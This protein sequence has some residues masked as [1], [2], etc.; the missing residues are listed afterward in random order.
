MILGRRLYGR[1]D[2][3][4]GLGYVAARFFHVNFVPLFPTGETFLVV[5]H[6]L[7]SERQELVQ[8]KN[9]AKPVLLGYARGAAWTAALLT[10]FFAAL[11]VAHVVSTGE[12]HL[13]PE[14]LGFLAACAAL[15]LLYAPR[16]L[17]KASAERAWELAA[18]SGVG[19]VEIADILV[20]APAPAPRP[21][22][23]RLRGTSHDSTTEGLPTLLAAPIPLAKALPT[24]TRNAVKFEC[25]ICE[26]Q[27]KVSA[28]YVGKKGPC[29]ACGLT[30][31]V[32]AP[33]AKRPLA[34]RPRP[35]I[36]WSFHTDEPGSR[37]ERHGLSRG[38]RE[39]R[40]PS[41]VLGWSPAPGRA[42][43]LGNP[44]RAPGRLAPHD[45][46]LGLVG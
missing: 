10:S 1:T 38:R 32:P 35:K 41:A 23:R 28:E 27:S 13:R 12:P 36:E 2:E 18:E 39:P 25:P 42:E 45:A 16:R 17:R 11:N 30:L 15:V 5:K 19:A 9:D 40:A 37:A 8:I 22:S 34:K 43:S 20:D 31:R 33:L 4:E 24:S 21:T 14:F 26:A 29:K 6:S 46:P 7:F 3:V 44:P